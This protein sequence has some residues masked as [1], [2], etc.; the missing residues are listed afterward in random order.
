M[1]ATLSMA[2]SAIRIPIGGRTWLAADIAVPPDARGVILFVHGDGSSRHSPRNRVVASAL[3]F[4]QF[5]TVLADLLTTQEER[6][7]QTDLALLGNRGVQL[8]DWLSANE[9][10]ATLPIGLFGVGTGAAATLDAAAARPAIVRAVVLRGGRPDLATKLDAVQA[11]TL[12]IAGGDDA[13]SQAALARLRCTKELRV[14][15]E[16]EAGSAA[17]AWFE[18]YVVTPKKRSQR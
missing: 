3:N 12:L 5:T 14:V 4:L 1:A 8:I 16:E 17:G 10:A 7:E 11:P 6:R 2:V 13:G 15:P 18:R 9:A